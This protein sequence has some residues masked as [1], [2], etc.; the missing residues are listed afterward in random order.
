MT[1]CLPVSYQSFLLFSLVTGVGMLLRGLTGFLFVLFFLTGQTAYLFD[2][3]NTDWKPTL[4]LGHT[5]GSKPDL[6]RFQR[7]QKRS[8]LTKEDVSVSKT[9]S[10]ASGVSKTEVLDCCGDAHDLEA[11]NGKE[12]GSTGGDG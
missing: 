2:T 3:S 7:S 5:E 8:R 6:E 10:S 11:N 12:H 1:D 4:K 9:S